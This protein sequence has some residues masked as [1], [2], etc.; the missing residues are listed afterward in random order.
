M[1]LCRFGG[2]RLGLV[3][4]D[5]VVDVTS[6]RERLPNFRY[7]LPKFDPFIAELDSLRDRILEL[8]DGQP[9]IPIAEVKFGSPVGN[10]GK[11]VAAPVNYRRHLEE[12]RE[13]PEIHH[14]NQI[15]EIERVGL[16]LKATSS[17]IGPSEAIIIRHPD[18]R[19]DH[20]IELAVVIGKRADRVPPHRASEYVA[21]Y[22]IGL[23][24]TV[25][26]PEERSLRKSID[27]YTVL[28]PWLVTT[29]ELADPSKLSLKLWV[30][31]E[32]RQN[33]NTRDLIIDVPGLIAFGTR[34]YTLMPGDVLLTGTPE[35]VGPI[36][37]GDVLWSEIAGIGEMTTLVQAS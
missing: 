17:V 37:P 6:I 8:A 31:G 34:F 19:T 10:P 26:G 5:H 11:I 18:R 4:Q 30:N 1:R 9:G 35:G 13:D 36:R 20:E 16:F 7:P 24:I 12:A 25:R 22:C 21:G 15:A 32:L 28:G 3:R 2:G 14:S 27:T 23:D 33:A 29:D